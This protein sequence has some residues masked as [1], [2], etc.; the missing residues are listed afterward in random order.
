MMMVAI[1]RSIWSDKL[2]VGDTD[3]MGKRLLIV[4]LFGGCADRLADWCWWLWAGRTR[5]LWLRAT[6]YIVAAYLSDEQSV[7][8]NGAVTRG[9]WP[10]AT[11]DKCST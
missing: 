4:W 11:G 1:V 7:E 9:R 6:S 10:V 2:M 5:L 8:C 3:E